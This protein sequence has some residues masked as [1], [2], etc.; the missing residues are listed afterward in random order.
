MMLPPNASLF[1]GDAKS[2]YT[3]IPTDMAL[4][5]IKDYLL[6]HGHQFGLS[7]D[8]VLAINA[9]LEI[10]MNRNIVRFGD[11]YRWQFS[12]TAMGTPPAPA[13]AIIFFAL[14]EQQLIPRWNER[15]P[16]YKRYIDDG[17]G[18]WYHHPDPVEDARLWQAFQDDFNDWHGLEW[19]FVGP[20]DSVDFMDITMKIVDGKIDFTLFEK[21]LNLYLYIPP[22]SAHPPGV[23]TGLIFGNILRIHQL[24]SRDDDINDRLRVFFR[25]LRHRGYSSEALLPIFQKAVDNAKKYLRTSPESRLAAK[26]A[27]AEESKRR[28]F[29]HLPYHPN[30]PPS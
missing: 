17:F 10:V 13:W 23:L 19:E 25:R 12:G 7:H 15:V 20:N 22:K 16:F 9:A 27:Q 29:L 24:C 11:I 21:A 18:I 30:D 26:R 3:N 8:M 14:K 5:L 1:T 4:P 28:V 6:D 2:M